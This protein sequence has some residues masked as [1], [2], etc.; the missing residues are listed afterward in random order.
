MQEVGRAR[1]ILLLEAIAGIVLVLSK[2]RMQDI[3]NSMELF[4]YLR[5][6]MTEARI[7]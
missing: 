2:L 6:T 5:S 4:T 7:V 3:H 1:T